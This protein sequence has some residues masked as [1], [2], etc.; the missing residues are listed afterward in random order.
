MSQAA[1]P[2]AA[3]TGRCAWRAPRRADRLVD[4]E[5]NVGNSDLGP[6]MGEKIPSTWTSYAFHEPAF[7]QH[8]K[9]LLEIGQRNLLPLGDLGERDRFAYSV[10]REIDHRHD[11]VAALSAQPHRPILRLRAL[12]RRPRCRAGP[13]ALVRRCWS[14]PAR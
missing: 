5:D 8:G 13:P 1:R 2:V 4:S 14:V 3:A 7:A 10:L 9:E 11:G 12:C 6:I